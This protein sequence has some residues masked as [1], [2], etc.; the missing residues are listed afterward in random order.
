MTPNNNDNLSHGNLLDDPQLTAYALGELDEQAANEIASRV[1]NDSDAQAFVDDVRATA[2]QL[3]HDLTLGDR[4]D[5]SAQLSADQR[6]AIAA[7]A[8]DAAP[9][10]PDRAAATIFTM[11]RVLWSSIGLAAAAC[12]TLVLLMPGIGRAR[13][14]TRHAGEF[15]IADRDEVE[16]LELLAGVPSDMIAAPG[17]EGDDAPNRA[18]GGITGGGGGYTGIEWSELDQAER[19]AL[20]V[21]GLYAT[22]DNPQDRLLGVIEGQDANGVDILTDSLGGVA[23]QPQAQSASESAPESSHGFR[24]AAEGYFNGPPDNTLGADDAKTSGSDRT[25]GTAD[26]PTGAPPGPGGGAGRAGGF[27]MSAGGGGG[28]AGA[29]PR[30]GGSISGAAGPGNPMSP[31]GGGNMPGRRMK[32]KGPPRNAIAPPGAPAV[33]V[34]PGPD[35]SRRY[36]RES[37]GLDRIDTLNEIRPAQQEQF[38]REAYAR[39]HD[40]PFRRVL[41]EPLSTFSID[42]DTAAYSNMRRFLD[43][44]QLP[45][46]DA[47]RIEELL[48]Y[49][50]YDYEAPTEDSEDPFA[51][52]VEIANCPWTPEHRLARVGI[53]GYEIDRDMRPA[54]NLVFLIDV[55]GSMRRANKLPLVKQSLHQLVKNLNGDDRIAMVVYAGAP[56][57]VLPSTYAYDRG[58]IIDAIARLESGGSTNGG[59]GI[60]L[61]YDVA[62]Q[63]YIEGGVNRVIL[64]TDGDFNVGVSADGD[65]VRL[66]EDKRKSG[67]FLSVLG[68]GT[69]NFQDSKMEQLSNS[70]NGNFAYIDSLDEA[71]KVLVEDMVGTL[72]TIAKDVKI[73]IE[74]N[75]A[76][77][78]AYRL[79]GYENR[80]LEARDFND[81]TK[82]A[83]EIGA[84][85]TV[86]A[87]YEIMPSALEADQAAGA[88][89]DQSSEVDPLKYQQTETTEEAAASGEMMTVKLRYKQPEGDI[90]KLIEMPIVDDGGSIEDASADLKFA[91]SVASFGMIM[92]ASAYRGDATLESVLALARQSA[93]EI[94]LSD[95][96]AQGDSETAWR[97]IEDFVHYTLIAKPD[98]ALANGQALLALELDE[99]AAAAA[100]PRD[101]AGRARLK[102]TLVRASRIPEL[103]EVAAALGE[104]F[105]N[106]LLEQPV[107]ASVQPTDQ[108]I[109]LRAQ[110]IELVQKAK[111]IAA[112]GTPG[113]R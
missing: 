51:V 8:D 90:S 59:A 67:V 50:S 30:G 65:L 61:A 23:G 36:V 9:H 4:A 83:G 53:K 33:R 40:N 100:L 69:G 78:G 2:G 75:P 47:V 109:D 62:Q 25:S 60:Q 21:Y 13:D 42:V 10:A 54:T 113:T 70:G 72:V 92:R 85:H 104:L 80:I 28:V 110:F 68:Y 44:G 38:N 63:H 34:A 66:I 7:H 79:I 27:G 5:A 112:P 3:A 24:P 87:L 82:D 55:S 20:K 52:H 73:Q 77:V 19:D 89:D 45:P 1:A 35:D 11:P 86:T 101:A 84:G 48:N 22:F 58:A 18:F 16:S 57:L 37:R 111:A 43:A 49:F 6:Q 91:A 29:G 64:C 108:P 105:P 46:P 31:G 81:D 15:A 99:A 97:M 107:E 76:V 71:K 56:G 17:N 39:I 41:D 14:S 32:P 95:L 12:I 74:F 98:L 103:T 93:A 26:S 96:E 94:E 106:E 102:R 88:D